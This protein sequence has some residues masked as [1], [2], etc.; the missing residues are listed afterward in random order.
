VLLPS[1]HWHGRQKRVS[2]IMACK[3]L[4]DKVWPRLSVWSEVQMICIWSSWC[5]CHPIM[6]CFIKI[7]IG[8]TFLVLSYPGCPD[9]YAVKW[10]SV[11]TRALQT[12]AWPHVTNRHISAQY[13][14][15]LRQ[16]LSL[17]HHSLL[18]AGLP[19]RL[20]PMALFL[21]MTSFATALATPSVMD[22]QTYVRTPYRI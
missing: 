15:Q 14:Q 18:K 12:V 21:I 22:V 10:V 9:M 7:K 6:S 1:E 5:H 2:G 3:K 16:L 20:T 17:W 8:L 13:R 11:Y 19:A 4:S